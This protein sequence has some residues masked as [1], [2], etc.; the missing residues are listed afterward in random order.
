MVER[1]SG[2]HEVLG[3]IPGTTHAN[4]SMYALKG[5]GGMVWGMADMS[6]VGWKLLLEKHS[7]TSYKDTLPR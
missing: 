6:E 5:S 3:L 2:V 1:L 4:L 7:W